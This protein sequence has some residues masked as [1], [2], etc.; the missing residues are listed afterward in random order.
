MADWY[1]S[2]MTIRPEPKPIQTSD[3]LHTLCITEGYL[4]SYK[5]FARM[6][7]GKDD[8]DMDVHNPQTATILKM[9]SLYDIMLDPFKLQGHCVVVDSAYM[10]NAMAQVGRE[11]WEINMV[12]MV[13]L[14]RT[15]GGSFG[16]EAILNKR[17]YRRR[18]RRELTSLSSISTTLSH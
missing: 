8:Q 11:V 18:Y 7:G 10:G 4:R 12:G 14:N 13:Q 1:H 15:N 17:R 5:L 16:V 9:V 3:T 6:D 2:A